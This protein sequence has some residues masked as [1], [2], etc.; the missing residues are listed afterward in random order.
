MSTTDKSEIK[1]SYESIMNAMKVTTGFLDTTKEQHAFNT[2]GFMKIYLDIREQ[3]APATCA[4]AGMHPCVVDRQFDHFQE[5]ME[6][7][8]KNK[9]HGLL[10]PTGEDV[11]DVLEQNGHPR[12]EDILKKSQL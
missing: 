2:D 8:E 1:K 3:V 7:Y 9:K 11:S 6:L 10:F 4:D 5:M 12:L